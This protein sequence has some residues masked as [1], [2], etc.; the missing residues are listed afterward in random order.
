MNNKIKINLIIITL[1]AVISD[2][3]LLPFYP[4]FFLKEFTI[5]SPILVG[6]Y[7][8]AISSIIMVS[9]PAWAYVAKNKRILHLLI[10]TQLA[11]SLLS[12]ICYFTHT[13]NYFL[14]I[15]LIMFS[16][17][18]SYLLI[19]PLLMRLETKNK[20]GKTIGLLSVIV[21]L[22]AL[23]GAIVGGSILHF[24]NPKQVFLIMAVADITQA[25]MCYFI[26]H[27]F[28][29]ELNLSPRE[30]SQPTLNYNFIF[31]IGLMVLIFYFSAFLT[32]PFFSSYW[33]LASGSNNTMISSII[34]A[35][36]ALAAMICLLLDYVY[37][38]MTNHRKRI[39]IYFFAGFLGLML[40]SIP[41][42]SSLVIGRI[43]YGWAFFRITIQLDLVV[44][45]LSKPENYALDF[46]KIHFFQN[47]GPLLA[48]LVAASLV[49][50]VGYQ[51][52]FIIAAIG[53]LISYIF[54]N[55]FFTKITTFIN[56][57]AVET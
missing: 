55:R 54:L 30:K 41:N 8:A 20:Q 22:G 49:V 47:L 36:P 7:I 19:Y 10:Y 2:S 28:N 50:H 24:F 51:F 33:E 38:N 29:S 44:F 34:Y 9:F 21:H 52:T 15:S 56:K 6:S 32:R 14:I 12:I 27:N 5:D 35:I 26:N 18:G 46:S 16:I 48:S 23:L 17:K 4:Q 3:M 1:I 42:I 45:E 39:N 40:Q 31:K 11:A 57:E 25:A 53:L 13:F 43:L 37:F